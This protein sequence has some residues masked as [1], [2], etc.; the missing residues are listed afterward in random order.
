MKRF[1]LGLSKALLTIVVLL[2]GLYITLYFLNSGEYSVAATVAQDSSIPHISVD[3]V[4]LHAETFGSDTAQVVVVVHGGMSDYSKMLDL[5]ELASNYLVVF[6]DQRGYGLSPRVP[7]EE[8]T[9]VNAIKDL[10]SVVTHYGKGTKVN[11]IGHS[12]G[13]MLATAYLGTYPRAVNKIVLAEPG[14]LTPELTEILYQDELQLNL[15]WDM[16]V[17]IVKCYFQ[18]LHVNEIDSQARSDYFIQ[19]L[20]ADST[21]IDHPF[22]AYFCNG[23]V[24]ND[25]FAP[26]RF[27]AATTQDR[28]EDEAQFD[29]NVLSFMGNAADFEDKIL[30]LSGECSILGGLDFQKMQMKLFKNIESV[31]VPHAGHFIFA[32]QPQFCIEAIQEYFNE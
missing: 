24:R 15:T 6:Y 11:I 2:I 17:H 7:I 19:A 26:L 9:K 32:E 5:K 18:S 3:Q 16:L 1:F 13:A 4:T 21:A 8:L 14:P 30:F 22:T 25:Q 20:S 31:V 28:I 23:I 27:N 29:K 10:H 12:W